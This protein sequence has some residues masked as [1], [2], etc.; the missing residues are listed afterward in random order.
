MAA[1]DPVKMLTAQDQKH[2]KKKIIKTIAW[3]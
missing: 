2:L 1:Q 3:T